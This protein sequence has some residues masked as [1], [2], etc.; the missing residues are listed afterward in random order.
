MG[1]IPYG[2]LIELIDKM[3][4]DCYQKVLGYFQKKRKRKHECSTEL[5]FSKAAA[6]SAL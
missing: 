1:K 6:A 2:S 4:L 5:G 3:R